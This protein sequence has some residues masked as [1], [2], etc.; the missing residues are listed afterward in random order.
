MSR[1]VGK[2]KISF[3]VPLFRLLYH[4]ADQ[5][6][7]WRVHEQAATC[8]G[9]TGESAR[10]S[11]ARLKCAPARHGRI[12]RGRRPTEMQFDGDA[13][14]TAA[15]SSTG[16]RK[17]TWRSGVAHSRH[18]PAWPLP[19]L[20]FPGRKL[21]SRHQSSGLKAQVQ[22][23]SCARGKLERNPP[24]ADS[25]P[26]SNLGRG[27]RLRLSATT[28]ICPRGDLSLPVKAQ[29]WHGRRSDRKRAVGK[30]TRFIDG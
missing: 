13:A 11:T 7:R 27:S 21:A 19:G 8:S 23:H 17:E 16:S 3:G 14:T 10:C 25:M 9:I 2:Q 22:V 1:S 12:G 20:T 30:E 5:S 29:I 4:P 26:Y 15:D 24:A 6:P 18:K 28:V